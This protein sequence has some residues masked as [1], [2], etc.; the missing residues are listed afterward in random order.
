MFDSY[1]I[2]TITLKLLY[3]CFIIYFITNL[4][5]MFDFYFIISIT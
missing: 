4:K 2:I 1:F 5:I 3:F